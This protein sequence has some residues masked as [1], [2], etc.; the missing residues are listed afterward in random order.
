M[1]TLWKKDASSSQNTKYM[2][3][4]NKINNQSTINELDFEPK[5]IHDTE[6]ESVVRGSQ[7]GST[8]S[9]HRQQNR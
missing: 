6:Y 2:K 8:Q 7:P 5:L 9:R 4:K 3:T 1:D